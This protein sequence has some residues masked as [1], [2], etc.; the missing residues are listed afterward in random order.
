TNSVFHTRKQMAWL[1]VM[2]MAV[3]L[4]V[5]STVGGGTSSLTTLAASHNQIIEVIEEVATTSDQAIPAALPIGT[6]AQAAALIDVDSG[7]LLLSHNGDKKM[8]IASLTKVM[9]AIVAIEHGNLVDRVKVGR[10]A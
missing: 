3:S 8:L 4:L 9:T 10:R 5:G 7:R 2:V 6:S 1:L